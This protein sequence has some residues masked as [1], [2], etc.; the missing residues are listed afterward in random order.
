MLG[1]MDECMGPCECACP[2]RIMCLLSPI[3]DIP[4]PSYA[5]DWRARV[6][7]HKQASAEL[8]TK[9]KQLQPGSIVTLDH[10]ATFRDGTK[11]TAFR[12]RFVRRKTPIFEPVDRPGYWCRLRTASLAAATI[13]H[14]DA[15]AIAAQAGG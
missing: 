10:E 14:A 8:R 3:A 15:I 2:D 4:N 11:A 6:A 13:T 9:R 5:A 1:I 12:M 7:A